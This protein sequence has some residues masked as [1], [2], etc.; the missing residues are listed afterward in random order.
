MGRR[1]R[2]PAARVLAPLRAAPAHRVLIPVVTTIWAELETVRSAVR[3]LGIA[4]EVG[5]GATPAQI[6]ALVKAVRVAVDVGRAAELSRVRRSA[7]ERLKHPTN[8]ELRNALQRF[9][10][11]NEGS[12][13]RRAGGGPVDDVGRL[14]R[15][16]WTRRRVVTGLV[17]AW[18][19]FYNPTPAT[20]RPRLPVLNRSRGPSHKR[21]NCDMIT[22]PQQSGEAGTGQIRGVHGGCGGHSVRWRLGGCR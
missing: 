19:G 7:S 2:R 4:I 18:Q 6:E 21:R 20:L 17:V 12:P 8:R 1:K 3:I 13:Y 11:G 15:G 16:V 10:E 14:H 9:P 5:A 22:T